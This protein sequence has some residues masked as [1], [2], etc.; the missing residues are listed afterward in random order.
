[1]YDSERHAVNG[2]PDSL[3]VV[4]NAGIFGGGVFSMKGEAIARQV[5]QKR[6][7][8]YHI[9]VARPAGTVTCDD[10]VRRNGISLPFMPKSLTDEYHPTGNSIGYTIQ[11]AHLMGSTEI[12]LLGFT[13]QKGSRYFFGTDINPA[14]KRTSAYDL[15]RAIHWLKW[16][17]SQWPGRARLVEGWGGPVYDVLQVVTYEELHNQFCRPKTRE[18]WLV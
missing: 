4:A 2:C 12:Y 16:Y 14:T 15:H 18:G 17:E 6:I 8:P 3:V 13:L 7:Q 10:G 11:T 5:G 9:K 1:V